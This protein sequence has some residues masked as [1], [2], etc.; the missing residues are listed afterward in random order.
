MI[1]L[2]VGMLELYNNFNHQGMKK[3]R[4]TRQKLYPRNFCRALS[5]CRSPVWFPNAACNQSFLSSGHHVKMCT[6]I[7]NIQNVLIMW[8][9]SEVRCQNVDMPGRE[10]AN[11]VENELWCS[12]WEA[13]SAEAEHHIY[14]F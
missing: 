6:P 1:S 12:V 11:V 3:Y 13:N 5:L 8:S 4:R 7:A 9:I 14:T 2:T 10:Q